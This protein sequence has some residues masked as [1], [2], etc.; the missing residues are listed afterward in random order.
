MLLEAAPMKP[1]QCPLCFSPLEAREVAPCME[2]G[3][4]PEELRH[5]AEGKH[6][7]AEY[8][9]FGPLALVLCNFCQVDFDSCDPA[10]FGLPGTARIGFARMQ[11]L[12]DV[13]P[14]PHTFDKVCPEC[15][16]RLSY[17]QFVAAAR[18]LH[19]SGTSGPRFPPD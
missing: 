11:F 13:V 10:Y 18:E 5:F 7:Y 8:R 9:I 6:T 12:R 15:D 1:E 14:P 17:L 3:H 19:Q 16:H 2:C 4:D